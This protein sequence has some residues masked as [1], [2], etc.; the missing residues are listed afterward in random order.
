MRVLIDEMDGDTAIAR[1]TADAP[2]IDGKVYIQDAKGLV[3]GMWADVKIKRSDEHDLYA[4]LKN[5]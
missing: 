3:A 1:S 4:T 5:I 2:D